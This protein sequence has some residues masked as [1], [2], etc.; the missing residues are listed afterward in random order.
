M[1][2]SCC[3]E[4]PEWE[5]SK[6]QTR[7]I[8]TADMA[9][10][11]Q[12]PDICGHAQD[13]IFSTSHSPHIQYS[14]Q[15]HGVAMSTSVPRRVSSFL[16]PTRTD[17][18]LNPSPAAIS[19][20]ATMS[21]RATRVLSDHVHCMMRIQT[22]LGLEP[23]SFGIGNMVV[24]LRLVAL[25]PFRGSPLQSIWVLQYFTAP[26]FSHHFSR[27]KSGEVL[28]SAYIPCRPYYLGRHLAD[29]Q[30]ARRQIANK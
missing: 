7:H 5:L 20:V 8:I 2:S 12:Q 23:E 19:P 17:G 15:H 6:L 13:D 25:F 3:H 9:E 27:A 29:Q 14:Y 1:D 10:A 21:R 16:L 22:A 4:E 18:D 30:S 11:V 26:I 28:R 24:K